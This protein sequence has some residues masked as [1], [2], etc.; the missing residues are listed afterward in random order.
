[1]MLVQLSDIHVGPQFK[2]EI[3]DEAVHEV[4]DL[5]PDAVVITGDLTENGMLNEFERFNQQ[6]KKIKIRNVIILSGNH[7]YRNTGYLLFKKFFSSETVN[8]FD[9]AVIITLGT[10]RPD[11]DEGEVG[12]RQN[13]WLART[14]PKYTHKTKIIAMHHHMISVPDTGS[15]RIIVLDAGDV[16]QSALAA[17]V[18]LVLCGHKHRPWIWN[19]GPLTIAYAGTTSSERMRGFFENTYNIITLDK[20]KISVDLKVVNG[21]RI[22]LYDLAKR[23]E[24]TQQIE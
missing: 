24:I 19:L 13:L 20:G 15:D 5:N 8:E 6:I 9:D 14:L 3:F 21:E 7:D 12:Y 4:N 18:S 10:A 23:R 22:P 2:K 17:K 16:L 1:M 11:R